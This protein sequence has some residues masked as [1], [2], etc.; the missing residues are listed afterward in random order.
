MKKII[1]IIVVLFGTQAGLAWYD[2]EK[3]ETEDQYQYALRGCVFLDENDNGDMDATE[4][5]IAGVGVSDG[6]EVCLTDAG[7]RYLLKNENKDACVVFVSI[8]AGFSKTANFYHILRKT[9]KE[10]EYHF[11]LRRSVAEETDRF[12]FIQTTDVHI[13]DANQLPDFTDKIRKMEKM[14]PDAEFVICTGDL[15]ADNKLETLVLYKDAVSRSANHWFHVFGNHDEWYQHDYTQHFRYVLG[16]D[17]YSFDYGNWHFII[18]NNIHL[19]D[20]KMNTEWFDRDMQVLGKGKNVA[21]F[22]HFHPQQE[23]FNRWRQYPNIKAVFSGHMHG[24]KNLKVNGIYSFNTAPFR[25]G[26]LD[27]TPAGYRKV[28]IDGDSIATE[29]RFFREDESR[30]KVKRKKSE[31]SGDPAVAVLRGKNKDKG[32]EDDRTTESDWTGFKGQSNFSGQVEAI[33]KAPLEPVWRVQLDGKV[34]LSSPVVADGR[35]FLGTRNFDAC[36]GNFLYCISTTDGKALWRW[37]L[38]SP[39][40]VSP[41][42][43]GDRIVCQS[44]LGTVYCFDDAGNSLWENRLGDGINGWF[45]AAPV[46]EDGIIYTGNK[47]LMAALRLET[48]EPVWTQSYASIGSFGAMIPTIGPDWIS[49]GA[50]WSDDNLLVLDKATGKVRHTLESSGFSN[51]LVYDG[52]A[53]YGLDYIGGL[54][55]FDRNNWQL[56]ASCRLE[57]SSWTITTPSV[58]GNNIYVADSEGLLHCLRLEGE[59]SEKWVFTPQRSIYDLIPYHKEADVLGGSPLVDETQVYLGSSDGWFYILD[60]ASGAVI[61]RSDLGSPITATPTI[62]GSLIFVPTFDGS[63]YAFKSKN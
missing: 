32:F 13:G 38:D 29:C 41:A 44:Q 1:A 58:S 62:A 48:G 51:A 10:K 30:T 61:Q 34:L 63:L 23:D 28:R 42:I 55:V 5:G 2:I 21:L 50:Y 26:G 56:H 60:R 22:M 3:F 40:L 12:S 19:D 39:V 9:D 8:P 49:V 46:L 59:F 27:Y 4:K 17:Y 54:S 24:T 14:D 18:L 16:P 52:N 35:L 43:A 6:R 15:S 20:H 57:N 7:G 45:F 36:A 33:L 53:V 37:E 47:A 11:P 31:R 25:F